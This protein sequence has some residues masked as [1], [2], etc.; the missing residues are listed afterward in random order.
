MRLGS[1]SVA[2][3]GSYGLSQALSNNL[4][5]EVIDHTGKPIKGA[6]VEAV[7]ESKGTD[8]SGI[9]G[10]SVTSPGKFD[11]KATYNGL[12]VGKTVSSD[13]ISKGYTV[14][15]QFPVCVVDSLIRPIDLLIFGGAGAL[16]AAGGYFKVKPLE[17]AGEIA[18]GAAMFGFIYRL[19]CL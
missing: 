4:V 7:G 1:L 16:I 13:E 14:F 3:R 2:P 12:T 11:V 8:S 6:V 18:F 17:M 5:V 19:Q 9:A 10:F 15:L